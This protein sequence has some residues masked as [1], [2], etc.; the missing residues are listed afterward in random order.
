M[1]MSINELSGVVMI[2]H[3]EV[4]MSVHDLVTTISSCA[5]MGTHDNA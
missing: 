4:M 1:F 3:D 5:V 2:V